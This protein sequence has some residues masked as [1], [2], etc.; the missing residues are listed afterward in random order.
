MF[1]ITTIALF[2]LAFSPFASADRGGH[3]HHGHHGHYNYGPAGGY[4]ERAPQYAPPPPRY[5]GYDQR[6]H[7][8][9]AGG[10]IGSVVGYEMGNGNPVVAGL[11]AAAG[12]FLGNGRW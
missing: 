6:S 10:V 5:N 9:L 4:Y 8:G 11:G 7:Q 12:S 1:R 3:E 2:C